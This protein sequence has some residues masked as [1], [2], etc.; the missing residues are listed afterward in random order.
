VIV[1]Y[2]DIWDATFCIESNCPEFFLGFQ[3]SISVWSSPDC[4][5]RSHVA[6]GVMGTE[7]AGG[8]WGIACGV[9]VPDAG[10]TLSP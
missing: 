9:C 5:V 10:I 2:H 3:F 7:V 8:L 4:C 1:H 6:V